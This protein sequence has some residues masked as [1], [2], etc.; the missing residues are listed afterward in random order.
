MA[1]ALKSGNGWPSH[2]SDN[3][4]GDESQRKRSF[5]QEAIMARLR[6]PA[7]VT[8]GALFLGAPALWGR[9]QAPAQP[10]ARSAQPVVHPPGQPQVFPYDAGGT[11]PNTV[12]FL[13]FG[14]ETG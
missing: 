6:L 13:T 7:L 4:H 11:S 1:R 9:A 12:R 10:P 3:L 8:A 2:R 14:E 5:G